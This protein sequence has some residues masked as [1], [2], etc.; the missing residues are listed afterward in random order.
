MSTSSDAKPGTPFLGRWRNTN[1]RSTEMAELTFSVGGGGLVLRARAAQPADCFEAPAEVFVGED[2]GTAPEKLLASRELDSLHLT[3]HG[4]VK[5]GVLVLATFRRFK[6]QEGHANYFDREFFY[7][8][9][10]PR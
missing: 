4:W 10:G 6:G 1:P 8:A 2:G 3:M 9:D 7:R 5:Q